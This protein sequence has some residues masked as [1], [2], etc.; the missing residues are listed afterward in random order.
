M[1]GRKIVGEEVGFVSEEGMVV[2]AMEMEKKKKIEG[3]CVFGF[4]E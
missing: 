2:K 1:G 4:C 3:V